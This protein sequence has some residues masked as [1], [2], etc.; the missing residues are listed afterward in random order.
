MEQTQVVLV[1]HL[2]AAAIQQ[3]AAHN[4]EQ[5]WRSNEVVMDQTSEHE[6]YHERTIE[7]LEQNANLVGDIA[8]I[9]NA[10]LGV[11]ICIGVIIIWQLR[12]VGE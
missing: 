1:A 3:L 12:K 2:L 6:A 4:N 11:F 9:S 5:R 8:I 10:M 7:L